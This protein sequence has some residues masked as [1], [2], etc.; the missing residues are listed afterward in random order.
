[1][2]EGRTKKACDVMLSREKAKVKKA[3]EEGGGGTAV[4][5]DGDLEGEDG[6]GGANTGAKVS[7]LATIPGMEL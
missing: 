3:R 2:P 6:D 4:S 7:I 1:M 5:G